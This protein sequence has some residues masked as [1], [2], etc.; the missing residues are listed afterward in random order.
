[1]TESV[2]RNRPRRGGEPINYRQSG[3]F[4]AFNFHAATVSSAMSPARPMCRLLCCLLSLIALAS[5]ASAASRLTNASVRSSAGAGV[6][7]LIVGFT[8]TGTGSKQILLR[9]VGP[10]LATFGVAGPVADPELRV[11]NS[12]AAAVA[13]NDNW[14]NTGTIPT[15]GDAVGAFRLPA[16]SRDAALLLNLSA[17]S[18]SAHLVANS[19]PGI[20][21]VESYDADTGTPT[22]QIS[23]LSTRSTAGTGAA[24]LTIG[25][26]ITGDV[27]KTVLIRAVGPTLGGFGVGGVLANPQLRLFSSR[28]TELGYNDDWYTAAGWSNAYASVGAFSLGNTSTRDAALVVSLA[29]GSYTAQ[30][31]G[32]GGASGV[33]LIEV[34]DLPAIPAGSFVFQPV[35]NTVPPGYPVAVGVTVTP[36]VTFQARP[37]YPFDL[38]RVGAGGEALIQFVVGV[39]GRVSNA[40]ALRSHDVQFAEAGLAAVRQWIFQPGRNATGQNV[41]TVMQVPIVFQLN[42]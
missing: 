12:A 18:Y 5:F 9:G 14:D 39:D 32:V 27:P 25:F 19:G 28:N 34:Y 6:D 38:R 2:P 29:P 37:V 1:L 41:I 31:S 17:G 22:A 4:P 24:V 10:T 7:T 30:A 16:G 13:S 23:N 35:E 15:V 42:E 36:V 26:G 20:A 40:F 3:S 11:F 21:L 33:A 8:I